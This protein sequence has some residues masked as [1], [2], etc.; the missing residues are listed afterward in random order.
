MNFFTDRKKIRIKKHRSA[1]EKGGFHILFGVGE[2][3][4]SKVLTIRNVDHK[5]SETRLL[6][7]LR[8]LFGEY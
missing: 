5:N 6:G 7:F 4:I 3:A 8:K 2:V 1:H